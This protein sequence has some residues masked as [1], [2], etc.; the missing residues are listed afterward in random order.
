MKIK[1]TVKT[2]VSSKGETWEWTE[3]PETVKALKAYWDTVAK[4]KE[5][6]V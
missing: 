6:L 1:E 2:F 5:H 4:N 3:T